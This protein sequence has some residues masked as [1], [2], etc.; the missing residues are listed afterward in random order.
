MPLTPKGD[1]EQA[2]WFET[3]IIDC[4]VSL[5]MKFFLTPFRGWGLNFFYGYSNKRK[6]RP[7]A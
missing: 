2:L 6:Y 3:V 7:A 5:I 1:Y 4:T